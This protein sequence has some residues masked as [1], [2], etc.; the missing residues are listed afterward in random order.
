MAHDHHHIRSNET[1]TIIAVALSLA[2]M[3]LELYFGY[4]INSMALVMDGWHMLTHVMVLLLAY[5]TYKIIDWNL[6]PNT[7]EHRIL[8]ASGFFSAMLLLGVTVWM[9][10]ES[11][12]K[13]SNPE[14]DVTNGAL[15]TSIVG[16][17]VNGI[18]AYL[19]H[20]G[21]V[22]DHADMNLSAAYL[23]VLADV[24][25]SVFAIFALLSAKYFNIT[26][27]DAVCGVLASL[28]ILKWSATL[29]RKSWLDLNQA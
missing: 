11:L 17:V 2:A 27:M 10:I 7:S 6:F 15:I 13:F 29:L 5:F 1:R 20:E 3:L 23:H 12:M 19:L 18:A 9:L 28:I 25:L 8:S 14:I 24:I 26:W 21:H 16:L 22:H 4:T